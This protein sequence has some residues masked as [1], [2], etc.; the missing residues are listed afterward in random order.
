MSLANLNSEATEALRVFDFG[1]KDSTLNHSPT[2]HEPPVRPTFY[3]SH[4]SSSS[5]SSF[6]DGGLLLPPVER[7]RYYSV[8]LTKSD[9]DALVRGEENHNLKAWTPKDVVLHHESRKELIPQIGM[10]KLHKIDTMADIEQD[11]QQSQAALSKKVRAPKLPAS[12]S[13]HDL[14]SFSGLRTTFPPASPNL[15]PRSR[16]HRKFSFEDT[17][18]PSR[19]AHV[20]AASSGDE[21]TRSGRPQRPRPSSPSS[22][23]SSRVRSPLVPQGFDHQAN[24]SATF[25]AFLVPH[26]SGKGEVYRGTENAKKAKGSKGSGAETSDQDSPPRRFLNKLRKHSSRRNLRSSDSDL[27][28]ISPLP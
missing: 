27:P 16:L 10:Y 14:R 26:K 12:Q 7:A 20:R 22:G 19:S 8:A 3:S 6:A 23:S 1:F 9:Q 24:P 13:M 28:V 17:S 21:F 25:D 4:S 15:S 11:M 18:S 5:G 2:Q